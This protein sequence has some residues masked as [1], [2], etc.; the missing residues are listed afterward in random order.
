MGNHFRHQIAWEKNPVP[1]PINPAAGL[2]DQCE[3]IYREGGIVSELLAEAERR[4][5]P[6]QRHSREALA[7]ISRNGK[8]DQGVALDVICNAFQSL[9]NY[10]AGIDSLGPQRLLA[11]QRHRR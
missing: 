11:L 1:F 5:V 9:A 4:G 8:Q 10:L 7:R 6:V 3:Q 2:S